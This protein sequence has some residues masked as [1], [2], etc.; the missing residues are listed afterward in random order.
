MQQKEILTL[1]LC[2]TFQS[3]L[4]KKVVVSRRCI[5]KEMA[6]T[7]LGKYLIKRLITLLALK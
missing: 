6:I 5:A 7:N 1:S 2:N 4:S 3:T